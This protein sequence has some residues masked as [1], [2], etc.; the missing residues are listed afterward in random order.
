VRLW[1]AHIYFLAPFNQ[2]HRLIASGSESAIMKMVTEY[3][4]QA[5]EFER[6]ASAE[7]NPRNSS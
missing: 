4:A 2:E 7:N 6:I 3:L 1:P 5:A